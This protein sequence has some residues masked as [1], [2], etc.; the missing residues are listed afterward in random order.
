ML[1]PA[2]AFDAS[3][4]WRFQVAGFTFWDEENGCALVRFWVCWFGIFVVL[5]FLGG[6]VFLAFLR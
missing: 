6:L 4:A 1:L 3:A 5:V 2:L